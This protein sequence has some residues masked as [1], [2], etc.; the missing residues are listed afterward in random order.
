MAKG[1]RD[2]SSAAPP[3]DPGAQP[4]VAARDRFERAAR[5]LVLACAA[6]ALGLAVA[7]STDRTTGGLLVLAGWAGAV[8]ALH[9]LGRAGSARA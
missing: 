9:R 1:E 8:V 4:P 2:T 3:R 7:G 5:H 6:I